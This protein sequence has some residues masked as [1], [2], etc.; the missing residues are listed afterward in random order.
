MSLRSFRSQSMGMYNS[1][2]GVGTIVGSIMG[3]LVAQY[4]GYLAL[5]LTSS[6]FVLLSIAL[7]MRINVNP[8]T[9]EERTSEVI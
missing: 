4:F 1:V 3:G 9:E 6:T 2:R 5:F 7:L 8:M